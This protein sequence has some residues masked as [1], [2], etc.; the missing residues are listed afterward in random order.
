MSSSTGPTEFEHIRSEKN[1][2]IQSGYN[3]GMICHGRGREFESR[4]PRHFFSDT[5]RIGSIP[6]QAQKG[7]KKAQAP[8][9]C[10]V[11]LRLDFV[12]KSL[13]TAVCADRFSVVTA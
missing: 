1:R 2:L 13:T 11:Y 7:T 9:P 5:Y 10:A 12:T 3:K 6:A 4:R 8:G